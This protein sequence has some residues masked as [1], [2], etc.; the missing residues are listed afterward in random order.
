MTVGNSCTMMVEFKPTASGARSGTLT[1]TD[2]GVTSP[3]PSLSPALVPTFPVSPLSLTFASTLVGSTT[4]AKT[5][6]LKNIGTSAISITGINAAGDFAQANT[7]GSSLA[8]GATCAIHVTYTPTTSG[9]LEGGVSVMSSDPANPITVLL[10]GT[11]TGVSLSQQTLTF[12]ATKVGAPARRSSSPL[13][14]STRF[15]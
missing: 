11:A 14:T 12:P 7:C 8:A 2:S 15:H 9:T 10:K 5:V 3:Q 13:R 6:S 1:V 4:A